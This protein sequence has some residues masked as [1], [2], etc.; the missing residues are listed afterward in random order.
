[1]KQNVVIDN[2]T[3]V[4]LVYNAKA[5][6]EIPC[7]TGKAALFRTGGGCSACAAKRNA[8]KAQALAS[9]KTCLLGMSVEKRDALKR[10]LNA[11]T[12]TILH[13]DAHKNITRF[14]F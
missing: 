8:K 9:I 11:K 10:I 3:I 7:L 5:A 6:K 1:M 4:T 2:S 14:N 13:T 12:I